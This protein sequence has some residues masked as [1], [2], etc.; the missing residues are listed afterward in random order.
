MDLKGLPRFMTTRIVRT[1][2]LVIRDIRQYLAGR[3]SLDVPG[4][5]DSHSLS[6]SVDDSVSMR[7]K[8]CRNRARTHTS[9]HSGGGRRGRREEG[10]EGEAGGLHWKSGVLS[11]QYDEPMSLDHYLNSESK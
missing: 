5:A 6:L 9:A 11:V 1:Y 8:C 4:F 7:P 10:E 2:P 3:D